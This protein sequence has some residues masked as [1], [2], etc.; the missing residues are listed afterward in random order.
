LKDRLRR[1]LEERAGAPEAERARKARAALDTF[2]QAPVFTIH[3]FCQRV[4]REHAFANRQD[5]AAELV[6]DGDHREA[7]LRE[8]QRTAWRSAFGPDLP[9][10]LE[11]AGY[12]GPSWERKLLNIA[13]AYR[14]SCD[15]QLLPKPPAE[16]AV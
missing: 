13:G 11:L 9:R 10:I 5:F 16:L 8:V 15:H 7:C 1:K 14:E 3:G 2:D 6:D 4:L 12:D